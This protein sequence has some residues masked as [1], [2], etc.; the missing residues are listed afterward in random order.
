MSAAHDWQRW[1]AHLDAQPSSRRL[2]QQSR[3]PRMLRE[4]GLDPF[5]VHPFTTWVDDTL[6]CAGAIGVAFLIITFIWRLA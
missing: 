5:P 6:S 1:S 3:T 2:L 4:A